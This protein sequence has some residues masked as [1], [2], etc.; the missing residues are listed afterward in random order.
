MNLIKGDL[1]A[2]LQFA[3]I[4]NTCYDVVLME[5]KEFSKIRKFLGKTQKETASLLGVSLKAVCSYEQGWRTVPS[6]VERQLIFLLSRKRRGSAKRKNCWDL[7]NCPKENRKNCPAWE[8]DSGEFC[9]LINGTA[10]DGSA[11]KNWHEKILLCKSCVVMKQ[12]T[13]GYLE[14]T[15]S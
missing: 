3:E 10:C 9:W 5:K 2:Q 13:N 6:H 1:F 11:K 8:F 12:I 14:T 15:T 7:K 4:C